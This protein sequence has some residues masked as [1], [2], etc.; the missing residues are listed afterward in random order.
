MASCF[1]VRQ[2]DYIV[3]PGTLFRCEIYCCQKGVPYC[4][5]YHCILV[6]LILVLYKKVYD[7]DVIFIENYC[8]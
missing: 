4:I 7:E 5:F 1:L 2:F 6:D 3:S 8:E